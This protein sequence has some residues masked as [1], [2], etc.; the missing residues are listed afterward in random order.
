MVFLLVAAVVRKNSASGKHLQLVLANTSEYPFIRL[1]LTNDLLVFKTTNRRFT[2]EET[3]WYLVAPASQGQS[4]ITVQFALRNDSQEVVELAQVTMAISTELGWIA[5]SQW[6]ESSPPS[7]SN[8]F[9][10]FAFPSSLLQEDAQLLPPVTFQAGQYKHFLLGFMARAK[11]MD[12]QFWGFWVTFPALPSD[13]ARRTKP[14]IIRGTLLDG[15]VTLPLL[16]STNV[17]PR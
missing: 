8:R 11:N 9:F 14:Q 2:L 16:V 10:S 4:N 6:H 7:D 17:S 12:R 13:L 1:A 3:D 15:K 5:D